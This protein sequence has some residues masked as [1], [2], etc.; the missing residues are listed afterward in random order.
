[1]DKL[2]YIRLLSV[3]SID[4]ISKF[5]H[6]DDKRPKMRGHAAKHF[7]PLLQKEK[8]LHET[9]YQILPEEIAN[10]LSSKS[11]RLAHLYGLPKTHKATLSMRPILSATRTYNYNLAKWLEQ[12]L[13][14][15]SLNEYTITDAFAFADE[16]RTHTMNKDDIL[17]SY[18]V[19]ALFTNVPLDETIKINKA[20]TDDWFNITCNRISSLGYSKLRQPISSSSLM[21]NFTNRQMVCLWARTLVL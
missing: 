21:V 9:L 3:A 7:N 16:I 15:L 4:N 14:P 5:T 10:S 6:V 8:E 11:S 12:K 18:D 2:E 19:T 1:M 20:F 17:V 13:N